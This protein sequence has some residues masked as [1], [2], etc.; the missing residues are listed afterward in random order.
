MA[1]D[2]HAIL[3]GISRYADTSLH[4][5]DGPVRDVQLMRDWLLRLA[6]GG[7]PA[8]NVTCIVSDESG[9][10]SPSGEDLPPVFQ[11]FLNAFLRLVRKP[12]KSGYIRRVGSRLYLYF[13]GHGFCEKHKRDAHAALYVANADRDLNWNIYGTYFAQWVKDQGLFDEIVLIMDCCRDSELAKQPLV[14]PLRKPTDVGTGRDV[15]LF[16]LYAAPRGGKAQERPV[17][18][19]NNEVHG[20]LTHAFFDALDHAAPGQT[21]VSTQA[22]KGYLEERWLDLCGDEPA[23]PPEI[24]VPSNGEITFQR[25]AANDLTQRFKLIQLAAGGVFELIDAALSVIAHVNIAAGQAQVE[26]SGDDSRSI[27]IVQDVLTLP[28][29]AGFYM[30]VAP[31]SGG[32]G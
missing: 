28:L 12:D 23:D 9:Q 17:A 3:V 19:R 2:D 13:S 30:A 4:Q 18:T 7:L 11:D 26:R 14:P 15:R 25:G 10:L 16:E 20:L 27:A 24:V 5:L 29:P 31:V 32:R 8:A 6:G 1:L 21:T 22:I